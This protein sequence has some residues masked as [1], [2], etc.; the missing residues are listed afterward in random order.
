MLK[1]RKTFDYIIKYIY[2]CIIKIKT[3]QDTAFNTFKQ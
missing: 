3:H 2:S 1:W